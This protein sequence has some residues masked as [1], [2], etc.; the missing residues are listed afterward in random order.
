[1]H[2]AAVLMALVLGAAG[3]LGRSVA[4]SSLQTAGAPEPVTFTRDVAP[5]VFTH[6]APCH[7]DGGA[8]PFPLLSYADVRRRAR[9]IV[10]VTGAR[11]MPPWPPVEG[12]G[13]FK[14]ERRLD[15]AQIGTLARWVERGAVEGAGADLPAAPVF[16]SGWQLGTPDLVLTPDRAWTLPAEGGDVFRNFV[17]PVPLTRQR[18]VRAIEIRPGNARILHHA[19][20]LPDR[21]GVGRQ[22]DAA[23]P[24]AGF[25]GMDLE[26]ASDRFEPD[27]HFL[28][29]KPGTPAEA[30]ADPIPWAIEPGAD[31]ILNLHLRTSGKP[32]QVRPSLGLYFTDRTPT[33]FPMLL[34]LEHDGALDIPAGA[35]GFTVTDELELPVAV[36]VLAV[37]PHA[38]YVA[39]E[40]QALARRPDGS[41]EWLVHI[42]DWNLDWQA[43]YELAK[44]LSLPRGTVISMR[45]T[46]DNSAR[47]ERNP[48]NPPQ[49]VTAGDRASDEMSHLWVQVLPERREDL[50]LLQEA[51]MRARLRKY[52]GDFVANANLG[53]LLLSSNRTDEAVRHLQNALTARPDHAA[54]RNSLGTA[55]LA[56]GR[57]IEAIDNFT[58]VVRTSPDYLPAHYNLGNALLAVGRPAEAIA[59]FEFV[60][61]RTPQD[62]AAL[63]DLGSAL[64]MSGRLEEARSVLERSLAIN[65]ANAKAHY[66]LGLIA[67]QGGRLGDAEAHFER[68]LAIDPTD[69]DIA[70]ALSQARAARRR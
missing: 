51:L 10:K 62:A 64:A 45:W 27:S 5:I 48:H 8:G 56:A 44:P 4:M 53:A 32:E 1:M 21:S 16:A 20:A 18:F 67:A 55:L 59:Q 12:H 23:D 24:E 63:S 39:R 36:Q 65:P 13:T 15:P 69:P 25:A 33:R 38:H 54:A 46:Y 34:Q 40:V 68:A 57:P 37:Y 49:R 50:P 19:N 41:T 22:R 43:V 29:W 31:L 7:H 58:Q 35:A 28:F 3:G 9:Q 11:V 2:R 6:C 30:T 61:G 26:I 47:N 14:G 66:N 42:V 70:Q 52:P 60:L 17:L